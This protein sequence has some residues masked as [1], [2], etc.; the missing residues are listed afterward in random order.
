[1]VKVPDPVQPSPFPFNVQ[2][3]EIE[4]LVSVPANTSVFDPLEFD[5]GDW[6]VIP[7]VPVVTPPVLPARVK[8]PVAVDPVSKHDCEVV[9]LRLVTLTMLPLWVSDTVKLRSCVPV[10]VAVQ[11]PL[12][13][14]LLELPPQADSASAIRNMIATPKCFI[15]S[16]SK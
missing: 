14:L 4:L 5:A 8:V 12:M 2:F 10:R 9:K 15:E 16:S 1:M 13:V 11:F 3:P 6:I 7:K